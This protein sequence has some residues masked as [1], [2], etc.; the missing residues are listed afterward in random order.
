MYDISQ[1]NDMVVPELQDIAEQLNISNYKKIDKQELINKILDNQSIMSTETK[2]NQDEKPKRKRT[3]K[4]TPA[5][6][7]EELGEIERA[8][9]KPAKKFDTPLDKRKAIKIV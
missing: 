1:L 6:A 3:I 7:K 5:I 9:P 4:V 8:E 2:G